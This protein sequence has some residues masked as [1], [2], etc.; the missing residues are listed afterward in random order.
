[1][2]EFCKFC[3]ETEKELWTLFTSIDKDND[4]RLDKHELASA[5]ERSGVGV[6]NARLDRFFSHIDKD[7]DGLI[8]YNEWRGSSP[9]ASKANQLIGTTHS[10]C[11]DFLLFIPTQA[12]GLRAVLS[13]Y[14]SAAQLTAEGDVS[15]SD[16]AIQ[17][18]GTT[19]DFLKTSAFGAITSLVRP[20]N[21]SYKQLPPAEAA[22]RMVA[23]ASQAAQLA[24]AGFHDVEDEEVRLEADPHIPIKPARR[25]LKLTDLVPDVGYFVAGGVSGITS[26]TVT[27][28][29]DRLKVYLIAQTTNTNDAVQAAKS[30]AP[31]Q[32]G[33]QGVRTLVNACKDLWAAG[34]IRSLFAGEFLLSCRIGVRSD[35]RIRQRHQCYQSHARVGRQIRVL[36]GM[37][38][39]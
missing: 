34:G 31:V 6:S 36:R 15:I 18:L 13:Y 12:P 5:F 16:E 8:D 7:R 9:N 23:D 39:S 33:R 20:S 17:G 1:L 11:A 3:Q 26:R 35:D 4:G 21:P 19:L 32:A 37:F 10:Q 14:Q 29:L 27:A 24:S 25:K 28:P 38:Y 2:K 22:S 30:G